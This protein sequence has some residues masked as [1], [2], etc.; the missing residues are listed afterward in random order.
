M[1]NSNTP[2]NSASKKTRA[3]HRFHE[4][5]TPARDPLLDLAKLAGLPFSVRWLFMANTHLR[6]QLSERG[7]GGACLPNLLQT[8]E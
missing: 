2:N 5:G 7:C 1:D 6:G 4:R 3:A 8:P